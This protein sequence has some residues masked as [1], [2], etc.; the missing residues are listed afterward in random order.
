LS[1]STLGPGSESLAPYRVL[2][3]QPDWLEQAAVDNMVHGVGV[4]A[5][6]DTPVLQVQPLTDWHVLLVALVSQPSGVPTHAVVLDH[7]QLLADRQV[8]LDVLV[9][10][11]VAVPVQLPLAVFQVHPR[12]AAH[13]VLLTLFAQAVGT[14][15]QARVA[16]LQVQPGCAVQVVTLV[17]SVQAM[18]VPMQLAPV[19]AAHVQPGCTVQ[20][21]VVVRDVHGD[22]VPEHVPGP[23]GQRQPGSAA[24]VAEVVFEPQALGVPAHVP[25]VGVATRQPSTEGHADADSDAHDA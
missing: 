23:A 10:H 18:G 5:Q 20:E 7:A 4:P 17:L 21:V 14:P 19:D 9:E 13:M 15:L 2:T 8:V 16:L 3:A 25:A 1:Q 22:T 24:Q 12:S 6:V 11:A